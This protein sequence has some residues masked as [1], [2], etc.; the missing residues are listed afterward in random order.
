MGL[1]K[2]GLPCALACASKGHFIRGYDPNPQI[3][4]TLKSKKLPYKEVHADEYLE[5]YWG[6]ISAGNT[7]HDLTIMVQS[8][9][10]IFVPHGTNTTWI[11]ELK[12][13][14][15]TYNMKYF[16]P[17]IKRYCK[18][19]K[20]DYGPCDGVVVVFSNYKTACEHVVS[21]TVL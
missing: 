10:I 8:C 21:S 3:K 19:Y 18:M 2:L 4:E 17:Q 11:L 5:K 9:D 14:P 13:A 7:D 20:Q 16:H 6:N 12:I 15:K 1:G